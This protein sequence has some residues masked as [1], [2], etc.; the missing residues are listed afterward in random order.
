MHGHIQLLVALGA[1]LIAVCLWGIITGNGV[2][3]GLIATPE[4]VQGHFGNWHEFVGVLSYYR[5]LILLPVGMVGI[6]LLI[7][8]KVRHVIS[9]SRRGRNSN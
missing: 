1:G 8:A 9:T 5:V 2:N 6:I 7:I 3:T 4:E